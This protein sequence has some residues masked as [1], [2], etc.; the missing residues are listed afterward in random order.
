MRSKGCLVALPLFAVL[1][2]TLGGCTGG[3][4]GGSCDTCGVQNTC[5]PP[6]CTPPPAACPPA[7]PPVADASLKPPDA[8]AGE[9]WCYV[10]VPAQ[11]RTETYQECVSPASC[12]QEWVPPVTQD[13]C[14]QV[15][16]R[17]Q[18]VR[19]IPIPAEYEDKCEQ[20]CVCPSKTEWRRVECNPSSLGSGEQVGECWTLVEIPPVYESR[21]TRIC[22]RPESCREEI[23]PPQF[24]NRTRCVTVTEGYYRNI[25]T[26][27]TFETRT[28]EIEV[29]PARWE[30]RRTTECE[31]PAVVGTPAPAP[32]PAPLPAPYAA[33]GTS[34]P[35]SDVP[36]AGALPPVE[37]MPR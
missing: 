34:A 32:T 27:A 9:V 22:T 12:R 2:L 28:R 21:T 37:G 7:C 20:I 11:T 19:R 13:V 31:V 35:G 15:C 33:P 1:A 17:Q 26:P 29:C 14:E 10:R 16:V 23:V 8:R 24:E 4:F 5:A 36:P 3:L 25:E 30:W 6:P 18:E